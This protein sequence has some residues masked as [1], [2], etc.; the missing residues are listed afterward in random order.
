MTDAE[1]VH[2]VD[3]VVPGADV[4]LPTVCSDHVSPLLQR[5]LLPRGVAPVLHPTHPVGD[6]HRVRKQLHRQPHPLQFSV[7]TIPVGNSS[8]AESGVHFPFV[9][10]SFF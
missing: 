6:H 5:G 2:H 9:G 10:L 4:P 3:G 7:L 1:D 8:S